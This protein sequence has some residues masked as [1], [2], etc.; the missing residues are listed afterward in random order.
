MKIFKFEGITVK[1]HNKREEGLV[2]IC[3]NII[4]DCKKYYNENTFGKNTSS[5]ICGQ[6][7]ITIDGIL[8][9][10]FFLNMCENINVD[11]LDWFKEHGYYHR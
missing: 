5:I 9:S 4:D 1:A 11:E 10:M 7:M 8:S 6:N 3:M 2:R